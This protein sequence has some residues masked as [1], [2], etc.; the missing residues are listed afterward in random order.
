MVV[1]DSVARAR[2]LLVDDI[3]TT[4][5]T[6]NAAARVLRRA[7]AEYVAVAVLARADHR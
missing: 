2:L 5:A 4:G 3:M 6:A 1:P 7:G